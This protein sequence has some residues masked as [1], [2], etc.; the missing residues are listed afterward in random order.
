MTTRLV[1]LIEK[2]S[3]SNKGVFFNIF[4]D[5]LEYQLFNDE[6]SPLTE[7]A[8]AYTKR[9][10]SAGMFTQGLHNYEIYNQA[11]AEWLD[12]VKRTGQWNSKSF[13]SEAA[14]QSFELFESYDIRL[15]KTLISAITTM[16]N[17]GKLISIA[18]MGIQ[19]SVEEAIEKFGPIN[20]KEE[21]I[22]QQTIHI[23]TEGLS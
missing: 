6:I 23:D 2:Y 10:C 20:L 5:I 19:I 13:Q 12:T 21:N 17:A 9:S 3:D 15:K 7:I 14:N 1:S 8:I 11:R 4:E 22:G 16:V 18:D